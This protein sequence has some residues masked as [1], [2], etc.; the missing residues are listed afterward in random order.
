MEAIVFN[1][2][3]SKRER[4]TSH[5]SQVSEILSQERASG[6]NSRS[7]QPI[8]QN[9]DPLWCQI[10]LQLATLRRSKDVSSSLVLQNAELLPLTTPIPCSAF[11][12]LA[13]ESIFGALLLRRRFE[14]Q[15]TFAQTFGV[16]EEDVGFVLVHL[17]QNDDV[18]WVAL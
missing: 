13:V 14:Q 16:V 9:V 15:A 18:G 3:R 12:A 8:C 5:K 17:T 4:I 7:T 6:M 10:D 2:Q 11:A 1:L